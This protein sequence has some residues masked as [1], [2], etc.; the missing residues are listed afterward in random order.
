MKNWLVVLV[1][2]QVG[3]VFQDRPG[4]S[5]DAN[6]ANNANNTNNSTNNATNNIVNNVLNN[7]NNVLNN[8][9]NNNTANN[10]AVPACEPPPEFCQGFS[11]CEK[12]TAD[13]DGDMCRY[14]CGDCPNGFECLADTICT[15]RDPLVANDTRGVREV[16]VTERAGI[17]LWDDQTAS[18]VLPNTMIVDLPVP[19][20]VAVSD[21][22]ATANTWVAFGQPVAQ[23]VAFARRG[24]DMLGPAP[25]VT[26]DAP[27]F[28]YAVELSRNDIGAVGVVGAPDENHAFVVEVDDNNVWSLGTDLATLL[29]QDADPQE[30][31]VRV[32]VS[33]NGELAAVADAARVYVFGRSSRVWQHRG[34]VEAAGLSVFVDLSN[35]YL[36]IGGDGEVAVVPVSSTQSLGAPE[37]IVPTRAD[38]V[39]GGLLSVDERGS[40]AIYVIDEEN[41]S[42][43]RLWTRVMPNKWVLTNTIP[44][45]ALGFTT[46]ASVDA[47]IAT[48]GPTASVFALIGGSGFNDQRVRLLPIA[49]VN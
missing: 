19:E 43:I 24:N 12:G 15:A 49:P 46:I 23:Q 31:G 20:N 17:V 14:N 38:F 32:A 6:N 3:C 16:V 27:G 8:V 30:F 25:K 37:R 10:T 26:S 9:T 47:G 40:A 28:G 22:S 33:P 11:V 35:D 7:L 45:E 34:T 29:P 1:M 36:A 42:E 2:L 13:L 21:I 5:E 41:T 18:M 48:F 44:A 4:L 39:G